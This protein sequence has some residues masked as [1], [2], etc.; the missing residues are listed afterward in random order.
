M[1]QPA[2]L[3]LI[4]YDKDYVFCAF[5]PMQLKNFAKYLKRIK[6]AIVGGG[7]VSDG[8]IELIK[9]KK[10]IVYETYGMT[11]TI[12][13]IAVKKLNNSITSSVITFRQ[14]KKP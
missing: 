8:I 12:T 7:Q 3:P 9:D 14:V 6:T 5:T 2:A 10:P 13:H 11:E 4:D 1:V